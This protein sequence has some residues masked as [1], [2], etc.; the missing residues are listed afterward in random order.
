MARRDDYHIAVRHALEHDGW[1]ITDDPLPLVYEDMNLF[2]DLGAERTIG[3]EKEGHK[4]AVEIKDFDSPSASNDLQKLMG[5]MQLYQWALDDQEPDRTLFLAVTR[6]VYDTLFQRPSFQR[7]VR[8]NGIK[9]LVFD[10]NQE[11][12]LQWIKPQS[13]PTS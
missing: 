13:T 6:K 5:Q 10:G 11:V 1:T 4:I 2:A 3:A 9:L 12:I 8:N 7:A